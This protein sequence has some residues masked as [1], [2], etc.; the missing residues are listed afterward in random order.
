MDSSII[1]RNSGVIRQR[2]SN[3]TRSQ[4]FAGRGVLPGHPATK[5]PASSVSRGFSTQKRFFSPPALP[6]ASPPSFMGFGGAPK[7]TSRRR[8]GPG[9]KRNHP[10]K[11]GDGKKIFFSTPG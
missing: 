3:S 11:T 4:T 7:K 8:G 1:A 5:V 9:K 2:R 10:G 6:P